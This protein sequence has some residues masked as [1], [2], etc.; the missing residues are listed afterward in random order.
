V[1]SAGA[2]VYERF[3]SNM[4][5]RIARARAPGSAE[6]ALGRG[7]AEL[8]NASTFAAGRSSRVLRRLR[9]QPAGWFDSWQDEMLA[10]LGDAVRD[11]RRRFGSAP[12]GWAWG[13]VR[14]LTL[15]N[16]F[17]RVK[18]LAPVF[19]RGP[20]PWGGDSNTVSQAGGSNPAVIASLRFVVEVGDWDNACFVLPGGQSGNPFSPHYDDMLPLWQRG[21]GVPIAWSQEAV[22]DASVEAL[23]LEPLRRM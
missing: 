14:P 17:G 12:E 22:Y 20:F 1:D 8:L 15:P 6:W 21:E 4:A 2:T 11:L 5:R 16:P 19:N 9:E 10:A 7:F 13:K 3:L 23:R 18:A